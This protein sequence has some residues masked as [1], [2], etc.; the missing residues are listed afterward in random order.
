MKVSWSSAIGCMNRHRLSNERR[1]PRT[2]TKKAPLMFTLFG[3]RG[4]RRVSHAMT[5]KLSARTFGPER[6]VLPHRWLRY[7]RSIA[8][9]RS[10]KTRSDFTTTSEHSALMRERGLQP[11]GGRARAQV[12][13]RYGRTAQRRTRR[14]PGRGPSSCFGSATWAAAKAVGLSCA[15]RTGHSH[16]PVHKGC[17]TSQGALSAAGRRGRKVAGVPL[18]RMSS[19]IPR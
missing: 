4:R 10:T 2:H 11:G 6:S 5:A 9:G 13:R 14:L 17:R 18:S 8:L 19:R 15:S 16:L 7:P 1:Q 12:Q 3:V